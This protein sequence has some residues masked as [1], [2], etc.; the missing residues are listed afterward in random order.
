[1]RGTTM[2]Q[3]SVVARAKRHWDDGGGGRGRKEGVRIEAARPEKDPV[4]ADRLRV[5]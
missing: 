3:F 5:A 2:A 1:V 4:V